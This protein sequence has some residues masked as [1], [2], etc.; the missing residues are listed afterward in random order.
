MRSGEPRR[1]LRVG[2]VG[3]GRMG[4]AV[5]SVALARGHTIARRIDPR[6][7]EIARCDE[8]DSEAVDVAIEFTTPDAAPRNVR[9]LIERGTAVVSGTTGWDEH[10]ME[11]RG[12]A[13]ERR[14]GFMWSPNFSLG[15]QA[16]FRLVDRASALMGRLDGFAPFVTELHHA[17][18]RDA[19]SGSARRLAEIVVERTPGKS[20][21]GFVRDGHEVERERV[22][23]A[24]VRA[25]WIPGEH[26]VGWDGAFETLELTHRVRD[27]SVFAE[28]AVRAAE[29]IAGR[30]GPHGIEDMLEDLLPDLGAGGAE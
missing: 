14:V 2:V 29:W 20:H 24:S 23:V 11:I 8:L 4:R 27:R 12:I 18:K 1:P 6:G 28:G 25:G 16:M 9:T 22:P 21:F 15:M 7:G 5:E 3:L 30:D 19:P 17:G 13:R 10:L 26:T